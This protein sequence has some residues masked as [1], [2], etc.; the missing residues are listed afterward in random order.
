MVK[1]TTD[2]VQVKVRMPKAMQ[3]KLQRRAEAGGQTLNAEIVGR[4]STSLKF[5]E[6]E[7]LAEKRYDKIVADMREMKERLGRALEHA[8]EAGRRQSQF[9]ER[10]SQRL[11]LPASEVSSAYSSLKEEMA[12][13][14]ENER[15]QDKS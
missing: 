4:L 5:I 13:E 6:T 9:V 2:A 3:R 11:K 15:G 14:I 10:L 7:E 8:E 1:K 12:R